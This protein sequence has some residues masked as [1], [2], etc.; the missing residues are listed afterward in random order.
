MCDAYVRGVRDS[1]I[2]MIYKGLQIRV[3]D[4]TYT[5]C[6]KHM[7]VEFVPHLYV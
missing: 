7:Y 5:E 6:V 2:C 3:G 4:S 1:F